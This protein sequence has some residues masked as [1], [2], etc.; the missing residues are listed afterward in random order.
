MQY[1]SITR[2]RNTTNVYCGMLSFCCYYAVYVVVTF[3]IKCTTHHTMVNA[4]LPIVVTCAVPCYQ[5]ITICMSPETFL[6]LPNFTGKYYALS[7][8]GSTANSTILL[9]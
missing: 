6:L 7:L 5:I 9:M 2:H 4:L 1:F 8:S 3:I